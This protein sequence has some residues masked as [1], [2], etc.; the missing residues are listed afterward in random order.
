MNKMEN[1][2]AVFYTNQAK[3]TNEA[4]IGSRL[5]GNYNPGEMIFEL[6]SDESLDLLTEKLPNMIRC[7]PDKDEPVSAKLM[8]SAV[9]EWLIGTVIDENLPVSTGIFRSAFRDMLQSAQTPTDE[10]LT[11]E[12]VLTA[13][14]DEFYQELG[15]VQWIV[16]ALAKR[17]AGFSISEGEEGLLANIERECDLV[18]PELKKK[19]SQRHVVRG[20]R[21]SLLQ[22]RSPIQLLVFEMCRMQA[23]NKLFKECANCGRIFVPETRNDTKYCPFPSPQSPE[24]TCKEIGA[25]EAEKRRNQADPEIIVISKKINSLKAATRR[26]AEKGH[27]TDYF[28][29]Q[30]KKLT[31]QKV[32]LQMIKGETNHEV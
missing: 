25:R 3:C 19:C 8:T 9:E 10:S 16:I 23:S 22:I 1:G 28:Q 17:N 4:Y 29:E 21:R 15:T 26:S 31:R 32:E 2:L 20:I 18:Y 13:W 11:A 27:E 24:K 12:Q 5:V 14:Y 6:L 30:I 7:F